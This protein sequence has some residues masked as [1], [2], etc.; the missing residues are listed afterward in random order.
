MSNDS[1]TEKRCSRCRETKL[2][3]AYHK[4]KSRKD[5]LTNQCKACRAEHRVANAAAMSE[6]NRTYT[7]AHLDY[8]R[9]YQRKWRAAKGEAHR[10]YK[11]AYR[12][13]NADHIREYERK[14]KRTRHEY[15]RARYAANPDVYHAAGH[16]RRTHIKANGG[17]VTHQELSTKRASQNGLCAYCRMPHA[18]NDL[19]IDHVIPI[20]QGGP[21]IITNIVFAC[22]ICNSSKGNR[23]PEQW[24]NR[25]YER[26]SKEE[27]IPPRNRKDGK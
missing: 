12:A 19:T 7:A 27:A 6:Y 24:T 21:H 20:R 1:P 5:G 26:P 9:E 15:V 2:L 23:T 22:G 11:R 17:N 25:W 13:A 3:D 14:H 10:E 16:R 8:Y 18:P 4:N